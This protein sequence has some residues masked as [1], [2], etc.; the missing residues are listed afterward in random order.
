MPS[1][2]IQ[3][4]IIDLYVLARQN[5]TVIKSSRRTG[6]IVNIPTKPTLSR[7]PFNR[8][9][10][11]ALGAV[12]STQN[13]LVI[14][15]VPR[16]RVQNASPYFLMLTNSPCVRCFWSVAVFIC[17][18]FEHSVR[19][20]FS[21]SRSLVCASFGLGLRRVVRRFPRCTEPIDHSFDRIGA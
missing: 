20:F 15:A 11:L 13:R 3:R 14:Q 7:Q 1:V 19:L 6:F 18:P 5:N 4:Y 9:F 10:Q 8:A 2:L 12:L 17:Y 16:V 21:E